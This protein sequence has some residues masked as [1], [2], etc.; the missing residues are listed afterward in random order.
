MSSLFFCNK[1]L[2]LIWK[3]FIAHFRGNSTAASYQSDIVDFL[4]F[5]Q[6]DFIRISSSDV[7]N[8][9]EYQKKRVNDGKIKP[10]TLAKKMRELNSFASYISENKE[11]YEVSQTYQNYFDLYR[12]EIEKV[13]KL[14][15]CI[16]IDHIDRLI[17]AAKEDRLAYCIFTLLYRMGFST[18]EIIELKPSD[19][20]IYE[21]GV[22]V[23]VPGR[24]EASFVPH[25]VYQIIERYLSG[26]NE[27]DFL[28]YNKK[29]KKLY[30]MYISRLMKKYTSL[31]KIPAYSAE[32]L[33]NSCAYTM[34]AYQ[35]KPEQ[36][37]R[38]MGV[39]D[40]Q[41]RR[42]NGFNYLDSASQ[43]T[44]NLVKIRIEPPNS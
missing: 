36:V 44:K 6:K 38:E 18:T 22:Y 43:V 17:T 35:A 7:R 24:R 40:K 39:T 19:F 29:G 34:F 3:D 30:P 2:Q 15:R 31:A 42:Y 26:Y 9:F 1:Q 12:N 23:L 10:S 4:E 37:A 11:K 13:S 27:N 5:V 33:R 28:F 21:N 41:I 8:Y 32:A 14:A 25:D 16:P 20:S